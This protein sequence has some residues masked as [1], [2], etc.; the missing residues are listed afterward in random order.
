MRWE[1]VLLGFVGGAVVYC[2]LL[3]LVMAFFMGADEHR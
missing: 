2:A 1:F 3:A